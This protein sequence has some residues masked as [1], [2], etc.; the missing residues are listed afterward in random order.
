M[1][2]IPNNNF[3]NLNH[4]NNNMILE[5]NMISIPN[6]NFVNLNYLSD[7]NII[8]LDNDIYDNNL[9]IVSI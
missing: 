1:I 3:I 2:T 6:N 4:L 7:N 9:Q 8:I 5:N